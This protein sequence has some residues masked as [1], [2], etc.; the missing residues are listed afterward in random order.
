M[1]N[2]K[3]AITGHTRGIGEGFANYFKDYDV[4]GFSKSNG[5][6]LTRQEACDALI[7]NIKDFN[8]FVNSAPIGDKQL[9][10]FNKIFDLW[11][12]QDKTM[13]NMG[14]IGAKMTD[15]DLN[16]FR[17]FLN[18]KLDVGNNI[19]FTTVNNFLYYIN[20]KRNLERA[21]FT[22]NLRTNLSDEG[23]P[24]ILN[25]NAGAVDTEFLHTGPTSIM[26]HYL[27]VEEFIKVF[28]TIWK[29]KDTARITSMTF[30][31]NNEV[32]K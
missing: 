8:I 29:L 25:L 7:H 22:S 1:Q 9:Y 32:S 5:W 14:S 13:I 24:Y 20:N 16:E 10:L 28:D 27:T 15:E 21:A 12:G 3:V 4:H 19:H 31:G 23:Y 18:E 2:L 30:L 11:N 17:D 6:D 26:K